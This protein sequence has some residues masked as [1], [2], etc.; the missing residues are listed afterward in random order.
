MKDSH[1]FI[2]QMS[3]G[4]TYTQGTD[5]Y[6]RPV[7]Y[8]HVAKHKTWDQD[9]K[10][11]EDFV[12]FQMESVRCLFAPTESF[13]CRLGYSLS[14]AIVNG[15]PQPSCHDDDSN[16][17]DRRLDRHHDVP[18]RITHHSFETDRNS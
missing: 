2:A 3:S 14:C 11:L 16:S 5:R 9:P 12:I 10:A 15:R 13:P 7:T 17:G 4:K 6:G 1:G 8:V 18:S